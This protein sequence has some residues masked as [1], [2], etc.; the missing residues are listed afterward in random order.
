ML[1]GKLNFRLN[2]TT[3]NKQSSTV[4]LKLRGDGCRPTCKRFAIRHSP[5]SD[6]PTS[7]TVQDNVTAWH[8][9]LVSMHQLM[10]QWLQ[11]LSSMQDSI[12]CMAASQPDRQRTREALPQLTE[13]YG[14]WQQLSSMAGSLV[15]LEQHDETSKTAACLLG[16]ASYL[17][18]QLCEDRL[19]YNMLKNSDQ[20]LSASH[21]PAASSCMGDWAHAR[22]ML[23]LQMQRAGFHPGDP[24]AV[25]VVL[26]QDE[27][28]SLVENLRYSHGMAAM[29]CCPGYLITHTELA[30]VKLDQIRIDHWMLTMLTTTPSKRS[31]AA[32]QISGTSIDCTVSEAPPWNCS[33]FRGGCDTTRA[34]QRPSVV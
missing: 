31:W 29:M 1:A 19:V 32:S 9:T 22:S 17:E 3:L 26:T 25:S 14:A 4:H 6:R 21:A 2:R 33:I 30:L 13:F 27:K 12:V 34:I 23:L 16:Q 20:P 15:V 8:G 24:S 10:Q 11:D 18:Q 7:D 28:R 5:C